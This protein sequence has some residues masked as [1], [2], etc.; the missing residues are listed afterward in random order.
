MDY[1]LLLCYQMLHLA[2]IRSFWYVLADSRTVLN[3]GRHLAHWKARVLYIMDIM[4][5]VTSIQS[6]VGLRAVYQSIPD[7][8]YVNAIF[9]HSINRSL[10]SGNTSLIHY[11]SFYPPKKSFIAY[12]VHSTNHSGTLFLQT[13]F[14]ILY[15]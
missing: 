5:V 1:F 12:I 10:S 6:V 13:L 14:L 3:C 9:R 4:V 7:H 11:S 8:C 15:R 2:A